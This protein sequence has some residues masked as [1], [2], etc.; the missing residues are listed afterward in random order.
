[1]L[2]H[3]L[4]GKEATR[5]R[6][7]HGCPHRRHHPTVLPPPA[8]RHHPCRPRRPQSTTTV[9]PGPSMPASH[10]TPPKPKNPKSL[11]LPASKTAR[12]WRRP[13]ANATV[14]PTSHPHQIPNPVAEGGDSILLLSPLISYFSCF[15]FFSRFILFPLPT[16]SSSFK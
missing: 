4:K 8:R 11:T 5:P 1:M 13:A 12:D 15:L 14:L 16:I 9:G 2:V 7:L 10:G 3:P 6:H